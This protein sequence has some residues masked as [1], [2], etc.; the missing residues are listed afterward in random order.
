MKQE[1][2]LV[3]PANLVRRTLTK[4]QLL[5]LGLSAPQFSGQLKWQRF[6][7][8]EQPQRQSELSSWKMGRRQGPGQGL[9]GRCGGGLT[10]DGGSTVGINFR[11]EHPE[12]PETWSLVEPAA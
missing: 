3:L 11:Y 9:A 12:I 5:R 1:S 7:E 6:T 2:Q 4:L 10:A 8:P